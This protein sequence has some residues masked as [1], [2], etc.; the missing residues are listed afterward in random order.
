MANNKV[1]VDVIIDDKGNLKKVAHNANKA[2]QGLDQAAKASNNY[3]KSQKGVAGATSNSTKA[4]S[5][6]SG[7]MGG[8]VGV[9]AEVASR[10]FA[11]SAA[12]Q[13][14]QKVSDLKVLQ[15]SQVAYSS[16]TGVA[17]RSLSTDIRKAADGMLTFEEASKSAA[18]GI[19]SGL[20][21]EQLT[22]LAKG[23]AAVA[24]VLGRDVSDSYD[25]LVRGVTKAEPELLDELG[26]TLRLEDAKSKYAISIGKTVKQLTLLEQKQAVAVE[27]QD[28]LN[29]K[30]ISTT[31]SIDIQGNAM[32]KFAVAFNDVFV[33]FANFIGGPVSKVASFLTDNIY[34]LTAVIVLFASTVIKSMLPSLD[35]FTERAVLTANKSKAAFDATKASF[36]AM[37]KATSA[38]ANVKGALSG[39]SAAPGTGISNLQAGEEVSKR[40]AAALLRYANQQK[41][42]YNQLTKYQQTVYKKALKDILGQHETMFEKVKRGWYMIGTVAAKEATRVQMYWTK[43]LSM[44]TAAAT[45][46]GKVLDKVFRIIS[47]IGIAAILKD[48]LNGFLRAIGVMEEAPRALKEF[49][50]VVEANR[51]SIKSLSEEYSKLA[52]AMKDHLAKAN[53]GLGVQTPTIA[54]YIK[55]GNA[56]STGA[57]ALADLTE[58]QLKAREVGQEAESPKFSGGKIIEGIEYLDSLEEAKK[59]SKELLSI[60]G[61]T[62]DLPYFKELTK[63][64]GDLAATMSRLRNANYQEKDVEILR[65]YAQ[66]LELLAMVSSTFEESFNSTNRTFDQFVQ[67]IG[68]YKTSATDLLTTTLSE[69]EQHVTKFGILGQA[70]TKTL[71]SDKEKDALIKRLAFLTLIN[72]KETQGVKERI[73]NERMYNIQVHGSTKLVVE[74]L[75]RQ[76]KLQ[77][78]QVSYNEKIADLATLNQDGLKYDEAKK[79]A[80]LNQTAAIKDQITLLEE[81]NSSMYRL[82]MAGAQ[83]FEDGFQSTLKDFITG[84]ETSLKDAVGNLLLGIGDSLA[85]ELSNQITESVMS[86]IP[87]FKKFQKAKPEELMNDSILDAAKKAALLWETTLDAA[88][89]K[90]DEMLEKAAA[91]P[92]ITKDPNKIDSQG[93]NLSLTGKDLKVAASVSL[94]ANNGQDPKT[95]LWVRNAVGFD[96]SELGFDSSTLG[97]PSTPG[98]L[99][100]QD[101]S[102]TGTNLKTKVLDP[103]TVKNNTEQ[104]NNNSS[105]VEANTET[106]SDTLGLGGSFS[107]VLNGGMEMLTSSLGSFLS[108]LGAGGTSA[109]SALLQIAGTI[110]ST[111]LPGAKTGGIMTPQGKVQGY[112][113]GGIARGSGSGYPAMLHG[114]EAVVP[115]PNGRSI[116]VDMPQNAGQQQNNVVVNVS[117]DGRTDT[118]GSSGPD[119][120]KLGVAI[121]KAVQQELQS[122]KRSG[123]IL[124][125]YGAA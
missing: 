45:K 114:T 90:Y 15:E 63:N 19:A 36:Q 28:Q 72:D 93:L 123:G 70:L 58:I 2:G 31:S 97:L 96:P 41:G 118:S 101:K 8:M 16:T 121:A 71:S 79:Q 85:E 1:Q 42:V 13:F 64:A 11:L 113:T 87:L 34:S 21:T 17:I 110:A 86:S 80:L 95:A 4:F 78:L 83:A 27:V 53:E 117:A 112:A 76:K 50:M 52:F 74:R 60:L 115:L 100:S 103:N 25:R 105:A 32:N 125:P 120:D 92:A 111:Y 29:T 66:E 65:A 109:S 99:E 94:G 77:D 33:T 54:S 56:V 49:Q 89:K 23:A 38:S 84:K 62:L 81:A 40:Q 30:F 12:F 119:M 73:K 48:M 91:G 18:I 37:A 67:N 98:P 51:D 107:K 122:Q 10:V 55:L 47:Y 22:S 35:S 3:N 68:Q 5:K 116:P 20:G 26:I 75:N 104:T 24:K 6:M 46:L 7:G 59:S 82:G 61:E 39:V 124:S 108:T 69:I 43:A 57:K 102:S 88:T 106:L 9:Y 14:L 44:I